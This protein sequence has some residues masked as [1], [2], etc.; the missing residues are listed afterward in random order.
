MEMVMF[1]IFPPSDKKTAQNASGDRLSRLA[2][3]KSLLLGAVALAA[4]TSVGV[5]EG[6]AIPPY[7]EA[8]AQQITPAP[9]ANVTALPSFADLVTRVKP[10]VVSVQVKIAVDNASDTMPDMQQFGIEPGSPFEQFFRRFG[11]QNRGQQ[12]PH[13]FGEA[14]GSGFFISQDGYLVTNNHVVEKGTKVQVK[15]DDGRTLDAKVIGTDPKTD[16]ALLKVEGD[17][18]PYVPLASAMPR[19][20]DWVMAVGNP[21]GLGGT[22]TAGI[23]S[24]RGRDIGAGPYDDFIQIDAPINKGNSG[25]PTFNLAGQVVG[26]NTA[27]ASPSGG[28]VGIAF[29][30]PSETVQTVVAQLKEHGSVR[31]GYLGVQIQPVT[32]DIA[33][34]LGLEKPEGAIVARVEGDGPAGDAG[35]KTGDAIT[36]IDG[37]PVA[38]ARSLSREVAAHAPG[39]D[40]SLT[41]WR[42]GKTQTMTV[43]LA[44]MPGDKTAAADDTAPSKEAKL[45]LQLAPASS[46]DGAGKDGVV[47][48]GVQPGSPA[49]ERGLKSGDVIVEAAG[50]KVESPS[51]VVKAISEV[52]KNGRKAVLF[53]LKTQDGTR[54]VA[55]PL[56]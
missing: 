44:N 24:A 22:V 2:R 11:D 28:N 40:L 33:A 35:I 13:R 29:A 26:V 12:Q 52:R 16:L 42:D 49:D 48:V 32:P 21:F 20:G 41:V 19:V 15:T 47:V 1:D 14:Q 50:Q 27:I 56:A 51:D 9:N 3:R 37:K 43:K 53:R 17:S 45:G 10:A 38:D 34:S 7:K 54:F 31:R 46:I 30:I 4:V 39:S 18:F 8:F 36:A 25:G 23:V 6:V 5:L 55:L